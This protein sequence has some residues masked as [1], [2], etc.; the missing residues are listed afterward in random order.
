[1]S[2]DASVDLVWGDGEHRFK[3]AIGQLRELQEKCDCGPQWLYERVA[4]NR[5]GGWR[6]DDVRETIRLGL[7][8][9]GLK[10]ADAHRLC[11][12]Y[13]D[14]VPAGLLENRNVAQAIIAAALV[15]PPEEPVGKS[16]AAEGTGQS[17][18]AASSPSPPS[19]EPAPPSDSIPTPLTGSVSGSSTPAATAG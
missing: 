2:R 14:A 18:S 5:H 6:V 9:G 17:P 8:G 3:L 4:L 7:I 13:I 1:M 15:G 11:V 19:T 16:A 10:P 12:H